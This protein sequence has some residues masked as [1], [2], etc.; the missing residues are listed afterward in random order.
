MNRTCAICL[1][2]GYIVAWVT[3]AAA[4]VGRM[5]TNGTEPYS[6]WLPIQFA[7]L[8]ILPA[9]LGYIAGRRYPEW[10]CDGCGSLAARSLEQPSRHQRGAERA[11]NESATDGQS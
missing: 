6:P 5:P 10:T 2:V 3:Y 9:L 4:H 1:L 11:P 7:L 8:L